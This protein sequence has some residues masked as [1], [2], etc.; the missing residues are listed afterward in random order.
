MTTARPGRFGGDATIGIIRAVLFR[1]DLWWAALG[2]L[3]RL[4]VPGWW[5][6]RPYL[7][8]PDQRLWEFRMVTAYGRADAVPTAADVISYLEWCRAA[9]PVHRLNA[10]PSGSRPWGSRL[11][12]TGSG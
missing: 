9:G 7:P 11:D 8:V 12:P 6:T 3:R 5:R 4:A 10:A 2:A 1:P